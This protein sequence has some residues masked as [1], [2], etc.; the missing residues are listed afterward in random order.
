MFMLLITI[1]AQ[2]PDWTNL[3]EVLLWI[4]AGGGSIIVAAFFSWLA[5]NFEFWHK[6]PKNVKL[7]LSLVLSIAIGAGAYYLLSMPEL[8]TIIQPIYALVVLIILTW[9]GSQA[10]YMFAKAKSYGVKKA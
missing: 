5:E 9:L 6:I 8:I 4:V 7:I 2:L 1:L 3:N 10:A